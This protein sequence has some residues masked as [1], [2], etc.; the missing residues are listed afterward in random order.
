MSNLLSPSEVILHTEAHKIN[1]TSVRPVD[2]QES[3]C[4]ISGVF[5]FVLTCTSLQA[6]G[7]EMSMAR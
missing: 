6:L 2:I 1:T 3:R 7:Q 4:F 5:C